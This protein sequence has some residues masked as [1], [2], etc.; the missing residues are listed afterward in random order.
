MQD[1]KFIL[2]TSST[3][4]YAVK[5]T[6]LPE[7]PPGGEITKTSYPTCN[8][9]SLS[10]KPCIPYTKL[11]WN[12]ISKSWLLFLPRYDGRSSWSVSRLPRASPCCHHHHRWCVVCVVAILPLIS[13]SCTARFTRTT[14]MLSCNAYLPMLVVHWVYILTASVYR[15]FCLFDRL[16]RLRSHWVDYVSH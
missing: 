2:I 13:L 16:R 11:I 7:A 5:D 10:R 4:K 8:K 12:T 9:T 1:N 14:T 3:V 15:I 6:K